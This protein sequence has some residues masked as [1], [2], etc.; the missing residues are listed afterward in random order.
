MTLDAEKAGVPVAR[1]LVWEQLTSPREDGPPDLIAEWEADSIVGL[2]FIE[3]DGPEWVLRLATVGDTFLIG[4]SDEPDNLR[5]VAEQDIRGR[6]LSALNPDYL[7]AL[8]TARAEIERWR[9][10]ASTLSAVV[11]AIAPMAGSEAFKQVA[12]DTFRADPAYFV[13]RIA[14][15]RQAAHDGKLAKVEASRAQSALTAAQERIAELEGA[16]KPFADG[17][18]AYEKHCHDEMDWVPPPEQY[19]ADMVDY[20]GVTG[21]YVNLFPLSALRTA[22][23][24]LSPAVKEPK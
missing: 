7:S 9:E 20:L 13:H 8:D 11:H 18:D 19:D 12:P 4:R 5:L 14:E 21:S 2:Y 24:T 1:G 3:D 15:L 22:R 17:M 6:I 10:Y 16:L 23:A